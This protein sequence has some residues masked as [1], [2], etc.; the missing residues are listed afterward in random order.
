VGGVNSI[1]EDRMDCLPREIRWAI[2]LSGAIK[3]RANSAAV[4]PAMARS[5]EG[6]G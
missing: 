5:S 1:P 6:D 2:V 4:S 3:A